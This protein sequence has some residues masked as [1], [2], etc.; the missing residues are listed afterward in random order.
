MGS[1]SHR[2]LADIPSAVSRVLRA[3]S[4]CAPIALFEPPPTLAQTFERTSLTADIPARS[5][6]EALATFASQTGLQL[7]YVSDVVRN[8]RSNGA[9]AGLTAEEALA[10]LLEGTGLRFEYLTPYSVRILAVAGARRETMMNTPEREELREVI[11]TANRREEDQQNVPITIQVLTADTL[12]KLNATTFD[13]FVSFLP[14][15]TAH[16]VGPGQSNIF[17]RGLATAPTGVQGAGFGGVFPN[18]ALYIDEQSAQLPGRNL[19]LYAADLERIEVLEGPQGTLFGAGAEAGVVRYITNKPQLDVLEGQVNAGVATTTHGAPSDNF[20]ATI[21]IPLVTDHLAVRGVIYNERRGGYIDN[22]RASFARADTDLGMIAY[23]GG[24]VPANSVAINN[25]GIAGNNINPVTYRGIRAEAL[26]RLNDDW[27]ALLAQSYQS[28]EADGVFAEMA[29]NSL[30]QPQPDLSVQLFNPSYDNDKFENTALTIDGQVG[31]LKL[32]YAGAYLVRNVDQVQD[33]TSY[34]RSAYAPYYQCV[35][36]TAYTATPN[37]AAAQC[38]S[39]SATW[40]ER[41][42]NTHQTQELRLTTPADWRIRGVGGLFYEDFKLQ[43]RTDWFYLTATQYF[44]PIG[45]PTGYYPPLNSNHPSGTLVPFPVTSI[46]PNVRPPGDAFF[47]DITRGYTQKAAYASVDFDLIPSQLTLTLGSRY[48]DTNTWEVGSTV[49][50]YGCQLINNSNVPNPCVNDRAGLDFFNINAQGLNRTYSGFRSRANLSWKITEDALLYYTW[51]QGFRAGGFNR[52]PI[53]CACDS[54]LNSGHYPWQAEANLHGAWVPPVAYAPDTLTN[55][56][57]GWKTMWLDRRIQWDGA[58]Y[59][60]NWND[61]Q[62]NV[63][64]PNF[65]TLVSTINGGNYRVRGIETSLMA[66]VTGGLSIEAAAAWSHSELIKEATFRWGDGTP[67]NFATLQDANQ[68]TIP[69]PGGVLGSPLA[70]APAFQGNIRG[71]YEIAFGDYNTFAQ[72]GAVHQSRSLSTTDQFG[73][74]L[75]NNSTAYNLP[76]F[77]TY[78]AALGV[79]KDAWL[80]Q[81]Y[82]QNLTDTRAQLFA[83]YSQYYKGITVNRPRTI[84]LH[85][86]YS[87]GGTRRKP[88]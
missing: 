69:N 55:N 81:L 88:T 65:I 75:Q 87:F 13:D 66:R 47:N 60:E 67:I 17:M 16:G 5:L 79:G 9:A 64:A 39:P 3:L 70:G 7:V 57:L 85:F 12:A 58:I 74:D 59:Q 61:A 77:T 6:A 19:D 2:P 15:V 63:N 1:F 27:T 20:D 51:S 11:V 14:G 49:G 76:P 23:E 40:H 10:H 68:Q 53:N 24:K 83:N 42:R 84:G 71:R 82:G 8:R 35:N 41:E 30:G 34:S 48:F 4:V 43:D 25:F 22:I 45:P 44:N 54:P 52:A 50:S 33:Y 18:V 21:N 28:I 56:E 32:V 37:P 72:L 38:F 36:P 78:D 73:V 80:A 86:S 29:A 62:I 26:Y 46:D 31:A